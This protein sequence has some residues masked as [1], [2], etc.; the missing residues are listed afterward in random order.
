MDLPD[1]RFAAFTEEL[2]LMVRMIITGTQTLAAVPQA[3]R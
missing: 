2:S 3:V 1:D